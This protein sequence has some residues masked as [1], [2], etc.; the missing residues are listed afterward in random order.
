[1]HYEVYI[2][3]LFL[4]NFMMDSLLLLA[5]RSVLKCRVPVWRVFLGSASGAGLTCLTVLLPISQHVR[6]LWNLSG[7]SIVMI[8]VGLAVHTFSGL[9]RAIGVF[10]LSAFLLGG[11]L[12]AF[13]PYLQSGSLF[14]GA[15]A[16]AYM[17]LS[18]C[19]K[20]LLK[21]QN[22]KRTECEV[23]V[24]SNGKSWRLRA[25]I[26]TGNK[27]TDPVSKEP[28]HVIDTR[29]ADGIGRE[30]MHAMRY[31]PYRT[32]NGSGVMPII[33]MEKMEILTEPEQWIQNPILGICEELISEN[34]EYQMILNAEIF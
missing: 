9:L 13:R 19:W 17:I 15:A 32:V 3:V 8:L 18:S 20:L 25:L 23:R 29:T 22:E 24:F 7:V 28:V 14:F 10:F 21:I 27:L 26:D 12:Q 6:L 34:E 5:V 2:D 31:L 11:I 30:N 33:R 4:T 1:M 16:A